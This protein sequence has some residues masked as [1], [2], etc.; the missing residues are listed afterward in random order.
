MNYEECVIMTQ[1]I[2]KELGIVWEQEQADV[3]FFYLHSVENEKGELQRL[4]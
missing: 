1:R 2:A 3:L 4:L